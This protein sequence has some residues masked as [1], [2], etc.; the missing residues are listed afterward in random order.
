MTTG[1]PACA[2][3]CSNHCCMAVAVQLDPR[4]LCSTCKDD[5]K[6]NG[7]EPVFVKTTKKEK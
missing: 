6:L 4:H 3:L 5:P 7:P 2:P 1:R